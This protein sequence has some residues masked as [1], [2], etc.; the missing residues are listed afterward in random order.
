MEN[1]KG[2]VKGK[3][4]AFGELLPASFA[5]RLQTTKIVLQIQKLTK[6][7]LENKIQIRKIFI[8]YKIANFELK[9]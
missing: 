7:L 8:S 1:G 6:L 3:S 2:K 5:V 4:C 9:I